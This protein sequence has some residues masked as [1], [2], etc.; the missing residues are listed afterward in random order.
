MTALEKR[1]G[2][3]RLT[4]STAIC[5]WLL[6]IAG[7]Q[8]LSAQPIGQGSEQERAACRQDVRRFCQAEL[9]RNPE[10]MLSITGCLQANRVK[11]SRNCRNTLASHGQ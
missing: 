1:T 3:K 5:A 2:R 4:I 8:Q 6:G 11:I 9:Q 7:A 10:D